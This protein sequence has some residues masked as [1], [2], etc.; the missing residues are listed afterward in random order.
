MADGGRA[1]LPGHLLFVGGGAAARRGAAVH[2][3]PTTSRHGEEE[4]GQLQR[5]AED[6]K[7]E[8]N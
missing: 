2:V 7:P 1:I 3:D 8:A 5:D 6:Q 4:A